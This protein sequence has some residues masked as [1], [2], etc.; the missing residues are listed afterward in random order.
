MEC[1]NTFKFYLLGMH[2]PHTSFQLVLMDGCLFVLWFV[3]TMQSRLSSI[4]WRSSCLL[5][6]H[7]W[8]TGI[9]HCHC[10]LS[11]AVIKHWA[12]QTGKDRIYS[13]CTFQF[14]IER[15]EHRNARQEPEEDSGGMMLTGSLSGLLRH[16]FY[17]ARP[18]FLR[19]TLSTMGWAILY[20]LAIKEM[21]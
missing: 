12:K 15:S 2:K 16:I 7:A 3:L 1:V 6:L 17:T 20:Q 19:M 18:I 14:I 5:L 11:V 4:S 10:F 8:I 13:S 21:H 9:H